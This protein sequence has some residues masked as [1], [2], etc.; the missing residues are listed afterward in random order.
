MRRPLRLLQPRTSHSTLRC[1]SR[2]PCIVTAARNPPLLASLALLRCRR[3]PPSSSPRRGLPVPPPPT[4]PPPPPPL[5]EVFRPINLPPIHLLASIPFHP[6]PLHP[7]FSRGTPSRHRRPRHLG[8]Q[9]QLRA[10][11]SRRHRPTRPRPMPAAPSRRPPVLED[12]NQHQRA[13]QCWCGAAAP[14]CDLRSACCK[15]N[16]TRENGRTWSLQQRP[17]PC[18]PGRSPE[19]VKVLRHLAHLLVPLIVFLMRNCTIEKKISCEV[20][21]MLDLFL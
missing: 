18:D 16:T 19:P 1:S 5:L 14:R 17:R 12:P 8:G 20:C 9:I 11:P 10:R 21:F 4:P 15:L 13:P 6:I 7:S 2:S 3:R